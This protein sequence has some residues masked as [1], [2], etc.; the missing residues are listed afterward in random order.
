MSI[1]V[2][3]PNP[4]GEKLV[5]HIRSLGKMA[6]HAPLIEI[7]PGKELVLLPTKLAKLTKGDLVFFS[8]PN[9]VHHANSAL[10]LIGQKW[11]D[12]LSYYGIGHSTAETFQQLTN[13]PIQLSQEGETSEKLLELPSLQSLVGKKCLLLRGNGGREL[14]A[15]TLKS[16]GSHIDYCECYRRQ[17]IKY[18]PDTFQVQWQKANTTT[19]I[20]SS[21]EMLHILFNLITDDFKPWL[22]SRHLIIVSERLANTARQLGWQSV[23]A[24][25]SAN[26]D[27][28]IQALM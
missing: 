14:L 17:P 15:T 25:K 10:Y 16:R 18:D 4:S 27:A 1:L 8:S 20:V 19:I 21:G 2:T 28:L 12:T 22:L 23:K 5:Q 7:T 9:A 26:N 13:L 6:F 24:A 3:R 11:P